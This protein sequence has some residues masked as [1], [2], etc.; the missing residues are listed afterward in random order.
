MKNP[1]VRCFD[2]GEDTRAPMSVRRFPY[3][4]R[5][6][7]LVVFVHRPGQGCHVALSGDEVRAGVPHRHHA[8][9]AHIRYLPDGT[10]FRVCAFDSERF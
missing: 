8:Q 3:E 9:L 7:D 6:L 10:M 2:C 4:D 1:K 5:N